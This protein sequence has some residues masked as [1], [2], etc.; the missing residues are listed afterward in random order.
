M[1][2][3][4][5]NQLGGPAA[6]LTTDAWAAAA[7]LQAELLAEVDAEMAARLAEVAAERAALRQEARTLVAQA[8]ARERAAEAR[9]A[10]AIERERRAIEREAAAEAGQASLAE[11]V[12]ALQVQVERLTSTATP[13]P[14]A[15]APVAAAPGSVVD[16]PQPRHRR[17]IASQ[18]GFLAFVALALAI[19]VRAFVAEAFAV[20]T[21]SMAPQLE[22]HDTIVV[23]KLSYV[24]SA[25]RR[26]DV[27]V[28]ESPLTPTQYP[29]LVKRVVGLPGETVEAQGG[30][31]LVDGQPLDESY[32]AD[33]VVTDDFGPVTLG[34]DQWWVMGDNRPGSGD[35]RTFGP[36]SRAAV[37][38]EAV[39][40]AWP[41]TRLSFF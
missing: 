1:S 2:D 16:A 39:I 19:F 5:R 37:I 25:P 40:R 8:E 11:L 30:Q 33:G 13:S 36:I 9:E 7:E 24:F 23:S 21:T 29:V 15:A 18:I 12:A 26:G 38:G 3:V 34:D 31:V 20:P 35:S 17:S 32:L 22:S 10:E 14:R 41:P 28:F 27:V 6:P 4:D